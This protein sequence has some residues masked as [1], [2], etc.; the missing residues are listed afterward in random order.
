MCIGR[1][2]NY[3]TSLS[4]CNETW[5]FS[6]CFR[7]KKNLQLSN[8]T[9]MH[10]VGAEL[11]HADERRD[12]T[13]LTVACRNFV[14]TLKHQIIWIKVKIKCTVVQALRLCTGRTAHR[15]SRGI[16]LLLLDHGTRRGWVI[17]F[18]PRPRFPPGKDP[19]PIVQE[20]GWTPGL[21]WTG[22]ENLVPTEIWSSDRP[23]RCHT[24]WATGPN[25]II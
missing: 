14:N 2:V 24:G 17:N 21:L 13:K 25:L 11:F 12:M 20:A 1:Y 18:T 9:K 3:L 16:A 4:E 5:S 23:A 19:V 10:P 22:V 8:F 6:I 15:G 7:G